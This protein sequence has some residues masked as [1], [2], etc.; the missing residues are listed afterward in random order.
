MKL[1]RQLTVLFLVFDTK[2]YGSNIALKNLIN[3]LHDNYTVRPIVVY[4]KEGEF[5]RWLEKNGIENYQHNFGFAIYPKIRSLFDIVLFI[6]RIFNLMRMRGERELIKL[7]KDVSPDI[8][9]TNVGPIHVGS[10]IARK[11]N[12]PHVWHIREYQIA[13]YRYFPFP[14]KQSFSSKL[15]HSHCISI[16]KDLFNYF[17]MDD[18]YGKVIYDGVMSEDFTPHDI[19]KKKQ[20]LYVGRILKT[21]GIE[22]LL[23]S[24]VRTSDTDPEYELY[25]AGEGD[26]KYVES[27]KNLVKVN[28][29]ED[30]IK[31]LGYRS[32]RYKLMA[33]ASALIVPSYKE[34]FGF[35]TVEAMFNKCL[36]IGRNS[37]GTQEILA[38]RGLGIL[39]NDN[40]ELDQ[41]LRDVMTHG[42]SYYVK[43]VKKAY[44]YAKS[45]FTTQNHS[46]NIYN[47]YLKIL[48]NY[49]GY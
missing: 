35:I 34:G 46:T 30:R 20:L 28:K 10:V 22:D 4:R 8:I 43:Q 5:V 9:H 32:D 24:F 40:Q 18:A 29:L 27:L 16:S 6:P 13:D 2:M 19:Q 33:Q 12:I 38:N 3:D 42:S 47:H 41:A 21:K 23:N 37:G 39:F 44:K 11:L 48:K 15:Q 31:F 7:V 26:K 14:S 49:E 17:D 45:N 1:N 36:V 25:I